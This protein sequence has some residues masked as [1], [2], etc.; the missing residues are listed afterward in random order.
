MP[1]EHAPQPESHVE[2]QHEL[3]AAFAAKRAE[4]EHA[5]EANAERQAEHQVEKAEQA[6]EAINRHEQQPEPV[7]APEASE[8]APTFTARIS[9]ALSYRE[10]MVSLQSKLSPLSRSFSKVIHTPAVEKTSEALETT[11]MRPSVALGA[12]VT[13]AIVGSIFSYFAHRYGY[14]MRG[15]ELILSLLVGGILGVVLEGIFRSMRRSR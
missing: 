5:P 9:Q 4:R 15:S 6:R 14:P 3:E 11:V 7:A 10:T 8:P 13:A 12:V 2:K 1:A